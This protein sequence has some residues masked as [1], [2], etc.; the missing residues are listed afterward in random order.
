LS[1]RIS[2]LIERLQA[3]M[4]PPNGDSGHGFPCL[5]PS[6]PSD[7]AMS[8]LADLRQLSPH[9]WFVIRAVW[10]EIFP[11]DPNFTDDLRQISNRVGQ[12]EF[13]PGQPIRHVVLSHNERIEL[14][15]LWEGLRFSPA[16]A[17]LFMVLEGHGPGGP[18]LILRAMVVPF[19]LKSRLT[20]GPDESDT[21]TAEPQRE[22]SELLANK[23]AELLP[24]VLLAPPRPAN[25]TGR[26]I[27]PTLGI[28]E[29]ID[30]VPPS[31]RPSQAASAQG[32]AETATTSEVT[33]IPIEP[34]APLELV[35]QQAANLLTQ[36]GGVNTEAAEAA[37]RALL[38]RLEM[39][40]QAF[41]DRN[42]DDLAWAEW[43]IMLA[44]AAVIR[45]HHRNRRSL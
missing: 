30:L 21:A 14:S 33:L 7:P 38:E 18:P 36:W 20:P 31:S 28:D 3:I 16:L 4:V 39:L 40:S 32:D 9:D 23:V 2:D 26:R 8:L 42:Q 10:R 37:A 17:R 44:M 12:T 35:F 29:V 43:T 45:A 41:V 34:T 11:S 5:N 1:Q 24:A 22:A 6:D 27:E 13:G 19:L 15:R 25:E